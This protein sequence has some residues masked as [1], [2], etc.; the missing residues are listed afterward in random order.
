MSDPPPIPT[1]E[2]IR[3]HLAAAS[4]APA[5]RFGQ[6]FLTDARLLAAMVEAAEVGSGDVVLEIGP[7]PGTLTAALLRAGASVVAIELDAA[8]RDLL[9]RLLGHPRNLALLEGDVLAE[10]PELPAVVRAALDGRP[11]RLVSNL[12]YQVASTLLVDLFASAQRPEVAV[13][14]VQREVAERLRAGAGT[15]AYGPL[16]VMVQAR[17]AVELLRVLPPGCFWPRPNVDSASVRLR[18]MRFDPPAPD[19]LGLAVHAAFHARRKGIRKSLDLGLRTEIADAGARARAIE[20]ALAAAGIDATARAE[21]V[22]VAAHVRLARALSPSL[23]S[24]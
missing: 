23:R 21:S 15:E 5:K 13:V 24:Q 4:A 22:D 11:W 7:G 2:D 3:R 1:L 14:T 6:N 19:A 9:R 20:S 17:A 8:M 16:S 10:R 12:P 18:P